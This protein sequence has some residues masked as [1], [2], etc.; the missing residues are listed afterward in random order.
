MPWDDDRRNEYPES[1]AVSLAWD[2]FRVCLGIPTCRWSAHEVA[3][4]VSNRA[5]QAEGRDDG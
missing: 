4:F 3:V 1:I 2:A 5:K